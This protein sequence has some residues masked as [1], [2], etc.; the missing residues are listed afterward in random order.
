MSRGFAL[1]PKFYQINQKL[2]AFPK[3]SKAGGSWFVSNKLGN[4]GVLL[5]GAFK[6]HIPKVSY[7][8]SRGLVLLDL[9]QFD[10][11]IEAINQY[12]FQGIENF[13]I[14]FWEEEKIWEFRWDGDLLYKK[15]LDEKEPHIWS[16]VTLYDEEK[17]KKRHDWFYHWL[18]TEKDISQHDIL[19]FHSSTRTDNK[20]YGLSLFMDQDL[21][22]TSCT[23]IIL[24]EK[25]ATLFHRDLIQNIESSL[26]YDLITHIKE[27]IESN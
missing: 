18:S 11:P 9:F 21:K 1:P 3:D 2:L 7:K 4:T 14:I 26:E 27:T 5:N 24:E 22:T 12:H 23:S 16:S 25:K 6:K 19:N 8:K 17:T 15:Q 10:S 13:T 20:E